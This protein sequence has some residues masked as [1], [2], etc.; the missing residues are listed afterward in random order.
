MLTTG[1]GA[2]TP[3]LWSAEV[4]LAAGEL[5]SRIV[6]ALVRLQE[7]R[8]STGFEEASPGS[9]ETSPT[10]SPS[11]TWWGWLMESVK[12]VTSAPKVDCGRASESEEREKCVYYLQQAADNLRLFFQVRTASSLIERKSFRTLLVFFVLSQKF[13]KESYTFYFVFSSKAY[14]TNL[15]MYL[16]TNFSIFVSGIRP[17]WF[18]QRDTALRLRGSQP[19]LRRLIHCSFTAPLELPIRPRLPGMLADTAGHDADASWPNAAH[20]WRKTLPT[21]R[22]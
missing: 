22:I 13:S 12:S 14:C 2:R 15:H 8:S 3:S 7:V 4:L 16:K 18:A 1:R 21:L 5:Q 10:A 19:Q 20:H 11:A 9:A 17:G 6:A